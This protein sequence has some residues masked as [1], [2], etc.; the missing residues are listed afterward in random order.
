MRT[1]RARYRAMLAELVDGGI[2]VD[3]H[4]DTLTAAAVTNLGGVLART[5]TR[6]LIPIGLVM[7]QWS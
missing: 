6:W 1:T 2:G 7:D 3:T 4:P 5:T